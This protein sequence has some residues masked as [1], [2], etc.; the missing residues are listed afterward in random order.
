MAE[1]NHDPFTDPNLKQITTQILSGQPI[2]CIS[3]IQTTEDGR[4][5]TLSK[6]PEGVETEADYMVSFVN[7]KR[8]THLA[9]GITREGLAT[10]CDMFDQLE[11]S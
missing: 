10:L 2:P 5:V 11:N 8:G 9:F 1:E 4:T 7:L 3:L 6:Y